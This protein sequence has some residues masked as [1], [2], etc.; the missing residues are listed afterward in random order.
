MTTTTM[1]DISLEI[2]YANENPAFENRQDRKIISIFD[3]GKH[4]QFSHFLPSLNS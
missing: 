4:Y 2:H 3:E 1:H